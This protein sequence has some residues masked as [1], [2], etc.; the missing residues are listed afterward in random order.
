MEPSQGPDL[1]YGVPSI[2]EFLGIR[3]RQ[4]KHR[5]E[6]GDIPTFRIGETICARRSSLTAWLAECEAKAQAAPKSGDGEAAD[7]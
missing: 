4:A 3:L 1:L 7:G 6:K 2:A 5:V